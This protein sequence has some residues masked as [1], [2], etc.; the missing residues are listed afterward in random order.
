MHF[1]RPLRTG[2]E[3][4]LTNQKGEN[5]HLISHMRAKGYNI[6]F[7][8]EEEDFLCL[9]YDMVDFAHKNKFEHLI[10]LNNIDCMNN[11][12]TDKNMNMSID[13]NDNYDCNDLID[14]GYD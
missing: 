13:C 1:R 2:Q 8:D 12:I 3:V 7:Q 5:P 10:D 14:N 11:C 4:H 9:D 6:Y